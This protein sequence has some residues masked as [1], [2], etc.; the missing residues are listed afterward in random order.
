MK[1][2][3]AIVAILFSVGTMT[4]LAV[5]ISPSPTETPQGVD[6]TIQKVYSII[7]GIACYLIR[8]SI[9]LIVIAV[10]YYG[11]RFLISQGEPSAVGKAKEG[12]L[13]AVIGIAV[14]LGTYTIIKTVSY[15]VDSDA[16]VTPLDCSGI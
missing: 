10:L 2:I 8:I 5:D 7:V 4:V 12:I 1:Y 15:A 14:I 9:A 6:L 13:Y 3:P 11:F 16:E